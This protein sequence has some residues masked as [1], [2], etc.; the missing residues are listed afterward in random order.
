M[1]PSG[2]KQP[3]RREIFILLVAFLISRLLLSFL[4]F[5]LEYKALSVYWQYLPTDTL[6]QHLLQGLWYD[7]AQPPV[8]NLFLGA[9]LQLFGDHSPTAFASLLKL[10]SLANILMLFSLLKRTVPNPRIPMILTMLYLLS[11]ATLYFE[12]ELFYTV[13]LSFL[14][15]IAALFIQRLSEATQNGPVPHPWQLITGIFLPLILASLTRSMYHLAWIFGIGIL[16]LLFFRKTAVIKKILAG[17]ALSLVLVSFW[18]IKN[19]VIFG[20]FSTSS[21]IGMNL[22]RTVFHDAPLHDSSRIEAIEPFSKLS[23]YKPFLTGNPE[24]K[25]AGLDDR[26]LLREKKDDSNL[27]L[28]AVAYIEVSR[29]YMD[30]GKA[31]IRSHPLSYLSNVAQSAIM[32]FAPAT[33]YPYAEIAAKKIKYYDLLYSFNLSE[34]ATNRR[35]RQ[36]ALFL[37]SI[38]ELFAYLAVF[39]LLLWKSIRQKSLPPPL[40]LFAM[41]TI[42]YVFLA[43]SFLEHYENMRFRYE[44]Q[45]LFLILLGQALYLLSDPANRQY[46]K[47]KTR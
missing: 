40:Q 36:I 7:H 19:Y 34:L 21:W 44:V 41:A 10:M 18:Y 17:L 32:F 25:Y 22:A 39:T 47:L 5:H 28:H 33:R 42:G 45:P 38:P 46:L 16:L 31:Y 37:S 12:T 13:F 24:A 35:Q 23:D 27:N 11:P 9:I 14:L 29:K 2:D 4:G 15:L 26:D 43:G 30:A 1:P 8:F 3:T 20:Q 6:R